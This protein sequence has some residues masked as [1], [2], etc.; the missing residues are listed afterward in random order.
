MPRDEAAAAAAYQ[1]AALRDDLDA[2][3][4]LA[5]MTRDGRGVRKDPVLAYCWLDRAAR[6][7]DGRA[8]RMA[9]ALVKSW[10]SRDRSLAKK[11]SLA[12]RPEDALKK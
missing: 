5:A 3:R 7:G 6:L 11:R 4:A 12:F 8:K 1:T 2:M 9:D 10:P